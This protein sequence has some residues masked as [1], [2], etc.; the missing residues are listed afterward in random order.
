MDIPRIKSGSGDFDTVP[1]HEIPIATDNLVCAICDA[2]CQDVSWCII[3]HP[4]RK[5]VIVIACRDH[6]QCS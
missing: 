4:K 5:G 2:K 6:R 3:S 1:T